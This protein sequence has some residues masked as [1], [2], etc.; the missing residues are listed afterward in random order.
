MHTTKTTSDSTPSSPVTRSVYRN[1]LVSMLSFGTIIGLVF[2]PF[3]WLVL[4]TDEALTL[5]FLFICISAGLT[6]GGVNFFLFRWF[7]SREIAH[8]AGG[9]QMVIDGVR[10]SEKQDMTCQQRRDR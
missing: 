7:V 1:L 4:G 6:V 2:P 8:L 10:D 5:K 3:A 9:M